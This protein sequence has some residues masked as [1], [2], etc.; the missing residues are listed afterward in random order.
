MW[1]RTQDRKT[2]LECKYFD[3]LK[4]TKSGEGACFIVGGISSDRIITLGTYSTK[5]R[6]LEVLDEIQECIDL[7]YV[8]VRISNMRTQERQVFQM[9]QDTDL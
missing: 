2:L 4:I 6:C 8:P 5:E 7:G 3:Y 9:P 1:V